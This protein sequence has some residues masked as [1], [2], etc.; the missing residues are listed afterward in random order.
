MEILRE[1]PRNTS[2]SLRPEHHRIQGPIRLQVS[3]SGQTVPSQQYRRGRRLEADPEERVLLDRLLGI[4]THERAAS[5]SVQAVF[6]RI[7]QSHFLAVPRTRLLTSGERFFRRRMGWQ[8]RFQF[9][10]RE[11]VEV[12]RGRG[13]FGRKW[14]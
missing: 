1:Q 7:D 8:F 3:S 5:T 13:R 14:R 11:R 2:T 9:R 12:E 4:E 10:G 6:T